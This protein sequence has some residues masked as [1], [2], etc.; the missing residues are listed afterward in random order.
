[1][2]IVR[3]LIYLGFKMFICRVVDLHCFLPNYSAQ[4]WAISYIQ[5]ALV[6]YY[7]EYDWYVLTPYTLSTIKGKYV[8]AREDGG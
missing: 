2:S 7:D 6:I 4:I 1:M 8:E 5:N 3:V